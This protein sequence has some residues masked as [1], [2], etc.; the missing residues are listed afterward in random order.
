MR[1]RHLAVMCALFWACDDGG[2]GDPDPEPAAEMGLEADMSPGRDDA[3]AVDGAV[4]DMTPG[5][6]MA[7]AVDMAP[8]ID[9]APDMA[10]AIPDPNAT[11]L[12][13]WCRNE[14]SNFSFFVVSMNALWTK[15]GH[16]IDDWSGGLGGNLGGIEGADA[17][18]Q[19]IGQATGH[20]HKT[21]RAFLSA[22]QPP[23]G[24]AIHAIE[25]IGEGPWYDANG[26]LVSQDLAGLLA[27]DRPQGDP[28]SVND[29]P[30]ECGVPLSTLGDSHDTL[31]GSN[32]QGRLA[33]NDPQYTCNNWTSDSDAVG[34]GG[35]RPGSG[36][37][38]IGHSWPRGGAGGGGRGGANWISDHPTR[39]CGK[40]ANL[41]QDGPGSG[42]C[43]GCGGGYGQWYC[44]SPDGGRM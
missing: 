35:G 37:V 9:M 5:A 1:T 6:D 11:F 29:L 23:G 43:V 26:R 21:W 42:T 8:A 14:V 16:A 13:E 19:A 15:S 7:P 2:S 32:Q 24:Q 40:G 17:M 20:G 22:T 30:D 44:F 36:G 10:P 34:V 3:A 31:T 41:L 39:G 27:G 18:C 33:S 25:R 38:M 28:A 12:G 4:V